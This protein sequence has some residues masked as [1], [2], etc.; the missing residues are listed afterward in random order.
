ME[1]KKTTHFLF[2]IDVRE[3]VQDAA[4]QLLVEK[5]DNG[6][7]IIANVATS[8]HLIIIVAIYE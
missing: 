5:L 4:N 6:G 1:S 7:E 3:S 2:K 8:N